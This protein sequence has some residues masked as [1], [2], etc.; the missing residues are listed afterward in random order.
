MNTLL[1]SF[2]SGN[3]EIEEWLRKSKDKGE[4]F[5]VLI[6]GSFSYFLSLSN[7]FPN[8]MRYL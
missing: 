8:E 4:K 1:Y 2:K 7:T 3:I 6:I 5:E